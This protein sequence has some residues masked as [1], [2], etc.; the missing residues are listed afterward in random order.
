MYHNFFI[1]SSIGG[2]LGC[3]HVL[4]FVNSVAMNIGIYMFLRIVI[5]SGYIPNSGIAEPYEKFISSLF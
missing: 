2:L 3:F 5:F 1:H 4:D